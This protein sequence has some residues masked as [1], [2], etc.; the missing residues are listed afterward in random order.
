[1]KRLN[2]SLTLVVAVS[3]CAAC[4]GGGGLSLDDYNRQGYRWNSPPIGN[5]P[6]WATRG[7]PYRCQYCAAPDL[8]GRPVRMH[9]VDYMMRWVRTLYDQ[10]TRWFNIIDDNFTYHVQYAKDFC[11]ALIEMDLPDV[12]F[13]TPNG[14]I[15]LLGIAAASAS[16][17]PLEVW[18]VRSGGSPY[19][20]DAC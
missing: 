17:P 18:L 19:S 11:R 13:G 2:S 1:M 8:N 6:L 5:A 9:S 20:S 7:C 15:R 12:G 4:G 10:G 16:R 14:R 3:L